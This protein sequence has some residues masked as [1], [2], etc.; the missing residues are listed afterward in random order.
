MPKA[1][2]SITLIGRWSPTVS[3]W[4]SWAYHSLKGSLL[5]FKLSKW[6][7]NNS[8]WSFNYFIG[9]ILLWIVQANLPSP[10]KRGY[11]RYKIPHLENNPNI[12]VTFNNCRNESQTFQFTYSDIIMT[13]MWNSMC[14]CRW[15][16]DAAGC[17]Q[18]TTPSTTLVATLLHQ[19][20]GLTD[21]KKY[22]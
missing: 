6:I 17:N 10:S 2:W 1:D 8:K 5:S 22:S 13:V 9:T 19:S 4:R 15:D 16:S 3:W 20:M 11:G 18:W 7:I 12:K 14:R 21:Y